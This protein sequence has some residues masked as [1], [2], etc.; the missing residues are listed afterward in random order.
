MPNFPTEIADVRSAM[1]QYQLP[2]SP[3]EGIEMEGWHAV[4]DVLV[5]AQG[6]ASPVVQIVMTYD[7]LA[8]HVASLDADGARLLAGC[9]HLIMANAWHG[10]GA[11]ASGARDSAVA[12][13]IAL[14][15]G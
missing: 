13:L 11:E 12:R 1:L 6:R 4:N 10:K 3:P 14:G 9:A 5:D 8:P 2:T 15:D 7:A